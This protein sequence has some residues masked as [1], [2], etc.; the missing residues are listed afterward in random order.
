MMGANLSLPDYLAPLEILLGAARMNTDRIEPHVWRIAAVVVVGAIMSIL[1]T[2][3]VNV[4]LDSLS[5]DLHS[6]LADIQW[7]ATGYMLALATVIP[8]SGWAAGRF[9]AKRLWIASVVLFTL[10]SVLCGLASSTE[11][12]VAFR[13]LQGLG[14]G[15]IMPVGQMM[16]TR[17]AGPA[18]LGRVMSVVGLAMILA[19]I[20]GPTV[21]GLLIDHLDWRWIFY[22]NVP[23]GLIGV[24][25]GLRFL[26]RVEDGVHRTRLDRTGLALLS[27]GLPLLVYGL[28]EVGQR[29]SL[30]APQAGAP[31]AIGA[32][33]VV[34]FV[35]HALRTEEPLL[36]VRLFANR[37]FSS[38]AV[39]TFV[40][41]A[42]L[43]G[44]MLVMPLYFQLV[45]GEDA[46]TTGLLLIPQG[47]G[48]GLAMIVAG[49]LTDRIGGGRVA[50][51]GLGVTLLTTIPFTELTAST[52]YTAIGAAMVGRGF[53]IGLTMMPAMTAAYSRLRPSDIA[54]AT[55]QLNVLQRVGGSIGTALLTVVLQHA[56]THGAQTPA[57]AA[58]AF[59][60]TYV[61]VLALSAV[62]LIPALV[63]ARTESSERDST[64]PVAA[65]AEAAA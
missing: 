9:G 3:I 44:A 21:G 26:P 10:G 23:I 34:A 35:L 56:L 51:A 58:A 64:V 20:F 63:L 1:D 19:P 55:P 22:V 13:V 47:V 59:G 27:L 40:L 24:V 46:V 62:A 17:A 14:G 36:D 25:M 30:S 49:R 50:L 15:M 8:V 43:F 38:A 45:R 2:T 11:S 33:L 61:W 28:A 39:T 37:S 53:G 32:A 16:L 29:G 7:V 18:R 31:L 48:A 5:R 65:V 54:H 4:A 52:S 41:G 6:P 57:G 12:L 42:S 60:H